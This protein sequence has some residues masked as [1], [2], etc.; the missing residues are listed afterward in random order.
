[1]SN[2]ILFRKYFKQPGILCIK[3]QRQQT[4]ILDIKATNGFINIHIICLLFI[5]HSEFWKE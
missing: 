3:E 1:M 2:D 4:I 5:F